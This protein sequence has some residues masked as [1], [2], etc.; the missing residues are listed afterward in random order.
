MK[1][2]KGNI[3][4]MVVFVLI[5]SCEKLI[6]IDLPVDSL[7][8]DKV[9]N[10]DQSANAVM[11]AIYAR[12]INQSTNNYPVLTTGLSA[13]EL[14]SLNITFIPYQVNN[15]QVND[16][17]NNN[18]WGSYYRLIYEAN[19]LINGLQNTSGVS[20]ELKSQL[21]A[22]AK[23]L[24]AYSYFELVNLYGPVPFILTDDVTVSSVTPRDSVSVIYQQILGDLKDA[25]NTLSDTYIN[26]ERTRVNKSAATALLARVNLYL[27]N[28]QEAE[29]EATAVINNA[30]YALNTDLSKV[31]IKSSNEIIFQLWSQNGFTVLGSN[32]IANNNGVNY[33][34]TEDFVNSIEAGDDRKTNWINSVN[35]GGV[36]Y[37][38]PFKYKLRT[39][40]NT[41]DA[42]YTVLF[43]LGEMYLVRAEARINNNK[44]SEGIQDLNILRARA[45]SLP[46]STVTDPLPA[47]SELLDTENAKL[48]V[49]QERRVELFSEWSHRWFD[50]KRTNR[51][52]EILNET[53]PANWKPTAALYP[54]PLIEI[55]ANNRLTQNPG[56][57][58]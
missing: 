10:N 5:T 29:M 26:A 58:Q 43:R 23:F 7:T 31:F 48:A 54:I 52:D 30:Q 11:S 39:T 41:P 32:F 12:M 34:L 21:I 42:E 33:V 16:L 27:G 1:K 49:E 19:S 20:A 6:E 22:E 55:N 57:N 46:T 28:F 4:A 36:V 14:H 3:F 40:N 25:E 18:I 38:Y 8:K 56:Y 35:I 2:I 44:I 45:R 53:K 50:L 51:A 24:R 17:I 15:I 9:F 37:Y 13:D 47:L